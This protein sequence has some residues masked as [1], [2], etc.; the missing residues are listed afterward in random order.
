MFKSS[1]IENHNYFKYKK[2]AFILMFL[3]STFM[4]LSSQLRPLALVWWVLIIALLIITRYYQSKFQS[5]VNILSKN[6]IIEIDTDEIR[7][8]SKDKNIESFRLGEISKVVV[9]DDYNLRT[10]DKVQYFND[11]TGLIS[12][13]FIFIQNGDKLNR[14]EFVM[15]SHYMKEEIKIMIESWKAKGYKVETITKKS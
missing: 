6:R 3:S 1:I 14:Y 7:I 11:L 5:L 13:N 4:S 10:N 9:K 2:I 15:P 12:D 8:I